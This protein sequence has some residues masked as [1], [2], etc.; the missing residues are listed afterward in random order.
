MSEL[1]PTGF[2]DVK[3]IPICVGDLIRVKHFRHYRRKQQ[4]W[5]YFRVGEKAG[6]F[7]VHNWSDLSEMHQCLLDHCGIETAEVLDGPTITIGNEMVM[8][9]ERKRRPK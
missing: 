8:W 2:H 3:G 6:R 7:V 4:M 9:C 5:L 1:K